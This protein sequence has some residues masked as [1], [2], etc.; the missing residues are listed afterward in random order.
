MYFLGWMSL[1]GAEVWNIQRTLTYVR[2]NL[3]TL[4]MSG[5][6]E[7]ATLAL[8]L[9]DSPYKNNPVDDNARVY[10]SNPAAGTALSQNQQIQLQAF[11]GGGNGR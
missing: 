11:G 4:D 8:A 7:C 1:A 5:C 2:A 6:D 3:P 9:G 10:N